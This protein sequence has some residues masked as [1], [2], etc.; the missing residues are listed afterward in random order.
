MSVTRTGSGDAAQRAREA[1]QAQQAQQAEARRANEAQKQKTAEQRQAIERAKQAASMRLQ[2]QSHRY[3]NKLP[4]LPS[5]P[6]Q[7]RP[8]TGM[9]RDTE[10]FGKFPAPS[11]ASISHQSTPRS[12]TAETRPT[13][14]TS[15]GES[16]TPTQGATAAP[17]VQTSSTATP[18][19]SSPEVQELER[20]LKDYAISHGDSQKILESA[21]NAADPSKTAGERVEAGLN[22]LDQLKKTLPED[23]L[24]ELPELMQGISKGLPAASQFA[25]V[26]NK[27]SD[28][29]A[30]K[31]DKAKAVVDFANSTHELLQEGT[32][33]Q[34][35]LETVGKFGAPVKAIDNALKL[36]DPNAS[37]QDK[38]RAFVGLAQGLGDTVDS[39]KDIGKALDSLG[40]ANKLGLGEGSTARKLFDDVAGAL[41]GVAGKLG[42]KV[43]SE[44]LEKAGKALGK[45]IPALGGVLS[46]MD[47]VRLGRIAADGDLP[48]EIRYFA[49]MGATL[50][51][52]DTVLAVTEAFGVGNIGLPAN[53][54]LGVAEFGVDVAV[55]KMMQDHKN[56]TFKA[57]D[58]MH[59]L[60]GV[61][62]LAQGPA[63][64]ANLTG[65]FG[66]GGSMDVMKDTVSVGG[67]YA[68]QAGKALLDFAKERGEDAVREVGEFFQGL[69]GH[70]QD[71]LGNVIGDVSD[72]L[73]GLGSGV[74]DTLGKIGGVFGF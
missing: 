29:E 30:S 14:Q 27:L 23:K 48:P 69:P 15:P 53:L 65:T 17:N 73:G 40:V 28:P 51:G 45:V 21:R 52:A 6:F 71:T 26:V 16:S 8:S 2:E 66:L 19:S 3:E 12:R 56:G 59:A 47:T 54:A 31:L 33:R 1:Q 74:K 20:K 46:G 22:T 55:D 62:A 50:N 32:S 42:A 25:N 63:G 18:P 10:G 58:E 49:G 67:K 61:S 72:F 39:I 64:L 34:K 70:L 44:L 7:E 38:A 36:T 11:L 4:T 41:D 13:H 43:G 5:S 24:K 57:S 68:A 9:R 37:V 60:I 35:L